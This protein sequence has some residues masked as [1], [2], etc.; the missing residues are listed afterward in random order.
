M[1]NIVPGQPSNAQY[2][3]DALMRAVSLTNV[4]CTVNQRYAPPC[5]EKTANGPAEVGGAGAAGEGPGWTEGSVLSGL[6]VVKEGSVRMDDTV[7]VTQILRDTRHKLAEAGKTFWTVALPNGDLLRPHQR[8]TVTKQALA[9]FQPQPTLQ[10][11][12][13]Q[14]AGFL[15]QPAVPGRQPPSPTGPQRQ[16]TPSAA[17]AADPGSVP[18]SGMPAAAPGHQTLTGVAQRPLGLDRPMDT[19]ATALPGTPGHAATNVIDQRGGLDPRGMTVDGNNAA[20][21]KKLAGFSVLAWVKQSAGVSNTRGATGALLGAAMGAGVAGL[22]PADE[23]GHKPWLSRIL[24]GAAIGGGVDY[25]AGDRIRNSLA[26]VPKQTAQPLPQPRQQ[27]VPPA[28]PLAEFAFPAAGQPATRNETLRDAVSHY[29]GG[30]EGFDRAVSDAQ[31]WQSRRPADSP[32]QVFAKWPAQGVDKKIPVTYGADTSII[33]GPMK[34]RPVAGVY[35]RTMGGYGSPRVRVGDP[36]MQSREGTQAVRAHELTHGLTVRT[37]ALRP[38]GNETP[39][40]VQFSTGVTPATEGKMRYLTS[41]AEIDARMAAI[42]RN[43]TYETGKSV[44]TPDAAAHAIDRATGRPDASPWYPGWPKEQP[45]LQQ[46]D[47]GLDMDQTLLQ[48]LQQNPGAKQTVIQ[49]ML[50]LVQSGKQRRLQ[51]VKQ[52]QVEPFRPVNADPDFIAANQ[53]WHD[54]EKAKLRRLKLAATDTQSIAAWQAKGHGLKRCL[55]C[56]RTSR[57]RC[58]VSVHADIPEQTTADCYDCRKS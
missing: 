15:P 31:A 18:Q 25:V 40:S 34:G 3:L 10:Q 11:A 5:A 37:P 56:N 7:F 14:M 33:N 45:P 17:G 48:W 9:S 36:A 22:T 50:E 46:T 23:E 58:A 24:G 21:I 30:R 8:Q 2:H 39:L 29:Y 47:R 19:R 27:P 1:Q 49:R 57:C 44:N 16:P 32:L 12:Q 54:A 28:K 38:A 41:P 42:K 55:G 52:A 35:S 26:G 53:V 43:Y 6:E 51:Q 13:Q 4:P 20:G